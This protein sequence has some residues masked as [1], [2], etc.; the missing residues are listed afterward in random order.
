MF[1]SESINI[2]QK[3]STPRVTKWRIA[4]GQKL[5]RYKFSENINR[6]NK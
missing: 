1:K 2:V 4:E 5:D 6:S 3:S